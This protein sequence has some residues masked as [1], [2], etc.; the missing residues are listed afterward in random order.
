MDLHIFF[1]I[2]YI[3]FFDFI[4][5]LMGFFLQQIVGRFL[6]WGRRSFVLVISNFFLQSCV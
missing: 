6:F 2:L 3:T 1:D 4:R 5:C